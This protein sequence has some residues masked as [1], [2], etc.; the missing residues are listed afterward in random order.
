MEIHPYINKRF[1]PTL[2]R[3]E[4]VVQDSTAMVLAM[5]CK[6]KYFYRIVLGRVPKLQTNQIYFDFGGIYHKFREILETKDFKE[7]FLAIQD[8]KINTPVDPKHKASH[9]T[10]ELLL[11]SC[12]VAYDYVQKE[13]AQKN[14]EV[15]A[16]EQ[17]FNIEVE[18]GIF[19]AGRADQI[20]K[21]RGKI[22]GRDFKTTTKELNY[23]SKG[24]DPNDQVTRYIVG[25]SAI[26]G[27]QIEGIII[28]VMQN[29]KGDSK[30]PKNGNP[31]IHS[32]PV[33]RTIW[34]VNEWKHEQKILDKMLSVCRDEDTWPME[35]HNCGW[36]DYSILCR[37]FNERALEHKIKSD[38]A[39]SPW[40]CT[41]VDQI[42]EIG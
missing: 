37:Q 26:H 29:L 33:S 36:C 28:E 27:Q 22:W 40:D 5:S 39:L 17:P 23:F 7:A 16:V 24:L 19:I 42:I 13:R 32:V 41:K 14:I 1:L 8:L 9:Y 3:T 4:P 12:M 25:E 21:W 10:K 34:Q 38:F 30:P 31:K 11:K 15:I 18:P 6:R 2:E 20:I 35:P